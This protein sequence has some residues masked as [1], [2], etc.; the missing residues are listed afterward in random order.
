[1]LMIG[2]DPRNHKIPVGV[3]DPIGRIVVGVLNHRNIYNEVILDND[4]TV[5]KNSSTVS[6]DYVGV[7]V[8]VD[9]VVF[10]VVA[11]GGGVFVGE[12]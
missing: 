3:D 6:C 9:Y 10:G 4:R 7:Y 11:S 5:F 8:L 1:M 12:V 2:D